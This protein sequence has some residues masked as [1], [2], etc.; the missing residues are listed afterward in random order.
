MRKLKKTLAL[1]LVLPVFLTGCGADA[2]APEEDTAAEEV[3]VPAR[4]QDDFYRY[5]NE[6]E[7]I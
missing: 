2:Q 3:S 4:P 1:C 6:E 7:E 5:V